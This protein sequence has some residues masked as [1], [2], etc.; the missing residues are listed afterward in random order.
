LANFVT[1][2]TKS[3]WQL[4]FL[5]VNVAQNMWK[6]YEIYIS[7]LFYSQV[8]LKFSFICFTSSY[9]WPPLV[10]HLPMD[11][12]H[13][14]YIFL[15]M[16]AT[17][18]TS[19]HGW[20]SLI[21]HL[22]MEDRHLFYIFP[23]M[24]ITYFTSSYGWSPLVLNLPMNDYH[25]FL[26]L[27]MDDHHLFYI[28]PWMIITCFTSCYGWWPLWLQTNIPSSPT[29]SASPKIKNKGNATHSHQ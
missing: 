20:S 16:T 10:L 18:F 27:A 21:L 3:F 8:W 2:A 1:V 17:C 12:H 5:G 26:H 25:L 4:S 14:F 29:P 19:S 22:P 7:L 13:L 23:W 11:D 24:I 28:F 6:W 9:G 15:W